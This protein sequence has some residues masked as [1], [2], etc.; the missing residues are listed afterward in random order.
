MRKLLSV[1]EMELF[2]RIVHLAKRLDNYNPKASSDTSLETIA[3]QEEEVLSFDI[4]GDDIAEVCEYV[5]L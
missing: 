2:R 5:G 1:R 4:N 3:Q